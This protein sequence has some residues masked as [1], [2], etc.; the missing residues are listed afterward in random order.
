[1]SDILRD[2][3]QSVRMLVRRPVFTVAAV[4]TLALGI[5]LNTATFSTVNGVLLRPLGGVESPEELIQI[6]RRWP[7]IEYG[8][9]SVPHY[10]S[11]RDDLDEVFEDIAAFNIVATLV[12]VVVDKQA[13][14]AILKTF[15]ASPRQVQSIFIVQGTAIG[16]VGTL[17]GTVG[18]V[19]LAASPTVVAHAAYATTDAWAAW[20]CTAMVGRPW[21]PAQ[22]VLAYDGCRSWTITS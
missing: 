9:V 7:G 13:D 21:A 16:L 20:C 1:M 14:I 3:R 18:G 4:M 22:R 11:L 10:Q 2:L 6:Y 15:G 5:G 12:I 17:L 19:L 8:S